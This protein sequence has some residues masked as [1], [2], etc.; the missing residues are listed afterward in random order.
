MRTNNQ[1]EVDFFLILRYHLGLRTVFFV[2]IHIE[3]HDGIS[4]FGNDRS[5]VELLELLEDAGALYVPTSV[6]VSIH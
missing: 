5:S 6:L 4:A 2:T 3:V 1:C